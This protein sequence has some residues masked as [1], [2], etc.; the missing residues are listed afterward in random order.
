VP[1]MLPGQVERLL[2]NLD[3]PRFDDR[4]RASRELRQLGEL[5]EPALV[6]ALAGRPSSEARRRTDELLQLRDRQ[7]VSGDA[8]RALRAVE[9]LELMGTAKACAALQALSAGAPEARL[10]CDAKAAVERLATRS[11]GKPAK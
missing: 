7:I 9:V 1:P 2:G 6:H 4:E 10:T 3:S 5:A 8:L 11:A